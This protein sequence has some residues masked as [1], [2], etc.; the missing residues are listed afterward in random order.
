MIKYYKNYKIEIWEINDPSNADATDFYGYR[1]FNPKG[2]NI[3]KDTK[4]MGDEEACYE[5][6]CQDVNADLGDWKKEK[7]REVADFFGGEVNDKI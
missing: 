3:W 7:K 5:N 2:E 4:D 1:V 6:A